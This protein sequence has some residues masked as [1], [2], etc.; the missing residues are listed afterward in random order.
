MFIILAYD[1]KVKRVQKVRKT[2]EKYL[3][4]VQRSVFEGEIT[5]RALSKLRRELEGQIECD[6]DAV[7]IYCRQFTGELVR[8]ELGKRESLHGYIL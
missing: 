3:Q 8:M 1:V 7:I 2:V 6:E 5:Q 4:P